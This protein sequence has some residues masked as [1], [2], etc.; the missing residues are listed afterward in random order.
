M[1]LVLISNCSKFTRGN[2]GNLSMDFDKVEWKFAWKWW[3]VANA[4]SFVSFG[5]KLLRGIDKSMQKEFKLR[6]SK[7]WGGGDW[8]ASNRLQFST[9]IWKWFLFLHLQS[10]D[11]DFN[12]CMIIQSS[13]N[14][15]LP[16]YDNLSINVKLIIS[17]DQLRNISS[18]ISHGHYSN[19]NLQRDVRR[20]CFTRCGLDGL[21]STL[22]LQLILA[23]FDY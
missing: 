13:S 20:V 22:K 16:A 1:H 4:Q 18:I 7:M 12:I 8:G 5:R 17:L 19:S 15:C 11:L 6:W 21:F 2:S 3:S 10:N 9:I 14:T 23:N